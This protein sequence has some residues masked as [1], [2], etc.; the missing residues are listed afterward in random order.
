MKTKP[1]DEINDKNSKLWG[2]VEIQSKL[3]CSV[4]KKTIRK[5]TINEKIWPFQRKKKFKKI[6]P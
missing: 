3:K 1:T 4:L 5:H 6:C 2:N